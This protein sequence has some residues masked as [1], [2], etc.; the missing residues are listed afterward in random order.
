MKCEMAGL[1]PISTGLPPRGSD[2][3]PLS[4]PT[5]D[6]DDVS[7]PAPWST[8]DDSLQDHAWA[9]SRIFTNWEFHP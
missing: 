4:D 9:G 5:A 2:S 3:Q 7:L 1:E 8:V 6:L